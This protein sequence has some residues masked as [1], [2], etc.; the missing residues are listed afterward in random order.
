MKCTLL[1]F[2]TICELFYVSGKKISLLFYE[3]LC[4]D[5]PPGMG[6][7]LGSLGS[8]PPA[9]SRPTSA[10]S[11]RVSPRPGSANRSVTGSH[12]QLGQPGSRPLSAQSARLS[13]RPTSS[14]SGRVTL[15]NSRPSS[16]QSGRVPGNNSRP[17]SAQSNRVVSPRPGSG[18]P[19]SAG[20][21][22]PG[23]FKT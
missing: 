21:G 12:T 5:T 11:A 17:S 14:Q 1:Y 2:D 7:S 16:A 23:N 18:R 3:C 8:G 9:Y 15:S 10:Q 19:G 22:A 6:G 4:I 13:P 20:S